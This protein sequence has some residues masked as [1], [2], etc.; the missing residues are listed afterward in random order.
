MLDSVSIV[1]HHST[2]P[3]ANNNLQGNVLYAASF[4][5]LVR[6]VGFPWT[7][8]IIAFIDLAFLLVALAILKMLLVQE[9]FGHG[10]EDRIQWDMF[11]ITSPNQTSGRCYILS[12]GNFCCLWFA[13][14]P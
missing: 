11:T 13:L 4:E 9:A 5:P 8:R 10:F 14:E 3:F 6:S 1:L 12:S 7:L 2:H